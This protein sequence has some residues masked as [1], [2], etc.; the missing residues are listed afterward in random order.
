MSDKPGL[1]PSPIEVKEARKKQAAL[2]EEEKRRHRCCFAGHR[3]D[4]IRRPLDDVKV[5]LENAIMTAIT[6]GYMSFITGMC[7]G[8][9]IWAGEIVIRLK[10]QY[11]GIRLIAAVPYPEFPDNWSQEWRVKYKQLLDHADVVKVISPQYD[12]NVFRMRN[13]WMVDHSAKLIAVSN[14]QRSGTQNTIWYAR[15]QHV[16][17]KTIK[18]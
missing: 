16:I 18:A 7:W 14:G 5:D 9:D 15:K 2:T 6:E 13:I 17:V 3:P 11:E 8:I 12:E 4:G 1:G 10:K